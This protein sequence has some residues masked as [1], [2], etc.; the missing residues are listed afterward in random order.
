MPIDFQ[1]GVA[2]LTLKTDRTVGPQSG[3]QFRAVFDLE[4]DI[5]DPERSLAARVKV[6]RDPRIHSQY[7]M[8]IVNESFSQLFFQVFLIELHFFLHIVFTI[9][10]VLFR[11][12]QTE[13][14][15]VT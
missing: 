2:N 10:F 4:S 9:V 5:P 14:E 3:L 15:D 6:R 1:G 11:L 7:A 8:A 12:E 13:S